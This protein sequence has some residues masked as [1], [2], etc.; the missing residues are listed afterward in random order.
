MKPTKTQLT[1]L[2]NSWRVKDAR[3][4]FLGTF[5]SIKT[6]WLIAIP[7]AAVGVWEF[8]SDSPVV[9]CILIS[10]AWGNI[11]SSVAASTRAVSL[12][13]VFREVTNWER[14]ESL[15]REHNDH[16]AKN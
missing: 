13:P 4:R 11:F 3:P 1:W 15:I 8:V 16:A 10:L 14:V 2:K 5:W 6:A 9:G 12:W 7:L